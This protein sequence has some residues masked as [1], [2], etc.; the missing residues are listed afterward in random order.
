MSKVLV[1]NLAPDVDSFIKENRN[2]LNIERYIGKYI[3]KNNEVLYASAPLYRLYFTDNDRN[4]IFL[5][6]G[7]KSNDISNLLKQIDEINAQ[8]KVVS[9]PFN[10]LMTILI[11]ELT[12]T[13]KT[14]SAESLIMYLTLSLY[15]SLHYKYFN[16]LPN[17]N[18]MNYTINNMNNKFLIKKYGVL[19]KALEHIALK[20]HE[21]YVSDLIKGEDIN[22]KDYIMNLRTRLNNFV[23][24]ICN[25]YMKNLK[26]KKYLNT[27]ED[28]MEEE[29]YRQT[30]NISLEIE[31][32][33]TKT[34]NSFFSSE[35]N[36]RFVRAAANKASVH[37]D[38]L[39]AAIDAIKE[40]ESDKILDLFRDILQIYFSNPSNTIDSMKTKNFVAYCLTIYGKSNIKDDNVINLKKLL[41][42]F[43][44]EYCNRYSDTEREATRVSYRKALFIY[45]VLQLNYSAIH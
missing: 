26:D 6:T 24:I 15:S 27:E 9:E 33:I 31:N 2:I 20:N 44:S 45:F 42:Y 4:F 38:T 23:K 29:N 3:D 39:K 41:N 7:I 8:W 12:K 28:S 13:N 5:S 37:A 34:S 10:L 25:E 16:Y 11:R 30:T 43:L 36:L 1:N 21:T 14:E 35:T 32:I 18:C 40:K 22:I 19:Y 17:E